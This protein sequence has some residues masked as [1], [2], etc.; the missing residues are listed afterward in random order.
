[1][2]CLVRIRLL[3]TGVGCG[4]VGRAVAYNMRGPRFQSSHQQIIYYKMYLKDENKEKR[5]RKWPIKN[6]FGQYLWRSW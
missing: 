1:M 5:C 2:R 6:F 3:G 4:S